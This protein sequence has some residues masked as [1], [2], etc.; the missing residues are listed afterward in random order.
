LNQL[1][2]RKHVRFPFNWYDWKFIFYSCFNA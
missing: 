1:G 2:H